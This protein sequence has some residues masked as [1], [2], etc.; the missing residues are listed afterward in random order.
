MRAGAAAA[1]A[2]VLLNARAAAGL[3]LEGRGAHARAPLAAARWSSELSSVR[4][5]RRI[6]AA[7][8][9]GFSMPAARREDARKREERREMKEREHANELRLRAYKK[10]TPTTVV[11]NVRQA[12][13]PSGTCDERA[14]LTKL[15]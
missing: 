8:D 2:A 11:H 14:P 10:A 3:L 15:S 7:A 5:L 12:K 6:E 4:A 13:R 9:T 1:E